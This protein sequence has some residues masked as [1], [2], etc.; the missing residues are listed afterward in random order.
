ML[1]VTAGE[2]KDKMTG[3]GLDLRHVSI[4]ILQVVLTALSVTSVWV[5]WVIYQPWNTASKLCLFSASVSLFGGI[6][7]LLYCFFFSLYISFLSLFSRTHGTC[8]WSVQSAN[9]I[10]KR[11][12]HKV[13]EW[14]LHWWFVSRMWSWQTNDRWWT[15]RRVG[16]VRGQEVTVPRCIPAGPHTIKSLFSLRAHWE[17]SHHLTTTRPS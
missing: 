11:P 1:W 8:T 2:E 15:A 14:M 10:E 12:N 4:G 3:F 5:K 16:G 9:I 13:L 17:A 7:S 6:T